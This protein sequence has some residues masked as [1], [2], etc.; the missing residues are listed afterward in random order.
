MA[1]PDPVDDSPVSLLFNPTAGRGRAGRLAGAISSLLTE[2]GIRHDAV[3]SRAAGDIE[4]LAFEAASA[5]Q[6]RIVV[7]GGDGSIYEAVNGILRA[8]SKAGLG[9]IPVGTG[10]DFAKACS[11]PLHWEHA[12]SL[13]ADRLT[14][15]APP[16]LLDA[17]RCNDRYFA[18]G[19]G[20]GFD[21]KVSAIAKSIRLKIGDLVYLLAIF[22]AMAQ[23]IESPRLTM[24]FGGEIYEGSLTLANIA[25]GSWVGGMFYIA[26]HARNDDGVLN[27]VYAKPVTRRRI[28]ALL[29]KLMNGTHL[30]APEIFQAPVRKCEIIADEPIP[31]HLDGEVQP[32]ATD[33]RIEI[34]PSALRLL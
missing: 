1:E 12:A 29:P 24:K 17:G 13:L 32:P 34:V 7:A 14:S 18:N 21:A 11:I 28:V 15:R 4:R 26:P 20:V 3:P 16:L 23:G 27:L 33:F 19:V 2:N 9:V 8:N 22:R 5:G 30:D 31:S 25:N 6:Q 10:N